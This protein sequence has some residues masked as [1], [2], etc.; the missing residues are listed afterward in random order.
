MGHMPSP[1]HSPTTVEGAAGCAS[2]VDVR[3]ATPSEYRVVARMLQMYLHDLSGTDGDD[4][5]A[6]GRFHYPWLPDFW[7]KSDAAAFVFL[8]EGQYAGFALVDADV[9]VPEQ[10][11]S[12]EEFF[13][14]RKYR[15]L[16]IGRQAAITLFQSMPGRWEVGQPMTNA[17]AQAFWR[18][19]IGTFADGN[20]SEVA[21]D[22]GGGAT[23]Q[24][25]D[26]CV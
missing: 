23:L 11:R 25:F 12:I 21:L 1:I 9:V 19:V 2:I 18:E 24:L 4:V 26:N 3:R 16:G 7:R 22:H 13:V 10:E 14:L 8:V 20:W 6:S 5:D 15:R 17:R